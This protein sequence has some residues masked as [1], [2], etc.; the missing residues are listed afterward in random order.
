MCMADDSLKQKA[1]ND[2]DEIARLARDADNALARD[3][4]EEAQ[5]IVQTIKNT[6][7]AWE[8]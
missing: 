4:V 1:F 6:A 3:D 8:G 7:A 2:L 5:R